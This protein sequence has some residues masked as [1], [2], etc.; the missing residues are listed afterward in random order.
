MNFYKDQIRVIDTLEYFNECLF[1]D[2]WCAIA[3]RV[4][5]NCGL[6]PQKDSILIL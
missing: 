1:H 4:F 2:C 5:E 6:R 3:I